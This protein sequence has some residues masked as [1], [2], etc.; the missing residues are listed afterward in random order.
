[1]GY[2]RDAFL[3]VWSWV[4]QAGASLRHFW[5]Q[6]RNALLECLSSEWRQKVLLNWNVFWMCD[7]WW[8]SRCVWRQRRSDFNLTVKANQSTAEELS[9]YWVWL[10]LIW[11]LLTRNGMRIDGCSKEG[12]VADSW[13]CQKVGK[14]NQILKSDWQ[15]NFAEEA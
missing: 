8:N 1:M 3:Y 2:F 5:Y 7:E 13:S 12:I 14:E 9:R 11:I 4:L 15:W 10:I 6:S